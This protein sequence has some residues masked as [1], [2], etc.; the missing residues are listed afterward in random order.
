LAEYLKRH[1]LKEEE[2]LEEFYDVAVVA[3]KLVDDAWRPNPDCNDSSRRNLDYFLSSGQLNDLF[4][5][6]AAVYHDTNKFSSVQIVLESSQRIVTVKVKSEDGNLVGE[7]LVDKI[8]KCG[9]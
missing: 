6:S 7:K 1:Y 3:A 9:S 5:R 4:F 8:K 2:F